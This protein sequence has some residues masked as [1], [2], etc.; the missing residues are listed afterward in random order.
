[1]GYSLELK[2]NLQQNI[3]SCYKRFN[4]IFTDYFHTD[5]NIDFKFKDKIGEEYAYATPSEN[6]I[7]Y[8]L[9][10]ILEADI[11]LSTIHEYSHLILARYGMNPSHTLEFAIVYYCLLRKFKVK[12][13][14]YFSLYDIQD[15]PY[16]KDIFISPYDFDGFINSIEF[17]T[18]DQLIG[19]AKSL[20]FIMRSKAIQR[21]LRKEK[22]QYENGE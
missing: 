4:K 7:T 2:N 20:A 17:T 11:E 6:S 1:M 12:S 19:K 18:L 15:D 8:N 10:K 9:S 21:A 13:K 3:T 16:V 22:L 5:L 14:N